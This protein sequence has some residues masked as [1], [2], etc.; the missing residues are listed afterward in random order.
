MLLFVLAHQP[1]TAINI[2]WKSF[3]KVTYKYFK[4]PASTCQVPSAQ[5]ASSAEHQELAHN[6]PG[7][8][9]G[10]LLRVRYL[11]AWGRGRSRYELQQLLIYLFF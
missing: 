7:K 8:V 3:K 2:K 1:Y 10:P 11:G 5:S 9:E 6:P 4:W